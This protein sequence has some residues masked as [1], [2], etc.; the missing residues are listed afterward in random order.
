MD[1]Q[2]WMGVQWSL[3]FQTSTRLDPPRCGFLKSSL[4]PQSYSSFC[5]CYEAAGAVREQTKSSPSPTHTTTRDWDA[6]SAVC[7]C[8]SMGPVGPVGDA[9][10]NNYE[11][12]CRSSPPSS[13]FNTTCHSD[14]NKALSSF[15]RELSSGTST[16]ALAHDSIIVIMGLQ[17]IMSL[18]WNGSR[19]TGLACFSSMERRAYSRS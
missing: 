9:I 14:L 8:P 13:A 11:K 12:Y 2:L 4:H 18:S 10:T 17:G 19:V 6:N 5:T 3:Y 15:S 16:R 7:C 1:G